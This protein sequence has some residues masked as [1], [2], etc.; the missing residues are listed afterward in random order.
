MILGKKLMVVRISTSESESIEDIV[1]DSKP[2]SEC[3]GVMKDRGVAKCFYFQN[4][5]L[6]SLSLG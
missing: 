2:C 5:I 4:G 6:K 3:I 1:A